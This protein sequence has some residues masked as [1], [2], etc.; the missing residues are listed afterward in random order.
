VPRGGDRALADLALD[1]QVL[2]LVRGLQALGDADR[3]T[4]DRDD[5]VG[6]WR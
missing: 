6:T 5:P 2:E 3:E 1:P 4:A